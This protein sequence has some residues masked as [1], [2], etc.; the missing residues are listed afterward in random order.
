MSETQSVDIS[1]LEKIRSSWLPAV[2]FLFG[3][4]VA[5]TEFAGFELRADIQ[6]PLAAFDDAKKPFSYTIQLPQK[7]LTNDV[8]LLADIM[9]ELVHGLYPLGHHD[10]TNGRK[11]T[12]I[13]EGAAVYGA[14][15]ALRQV[16]GDVCVD[17]YLNVLREQAFSYYDAFSYVAVLLADDPLAI[18]KLRGIHPFLQDVQKS[19]FANAEVKVDV[20]IKDILLMTFRA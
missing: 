4:P 5:E 17:E 18:K 7:S 11:T 1:K 10:Q 16:F 8:L 13:C 12:V 15:V 9:H 19:D 2:E 20:K 14:V 6:T 3:E